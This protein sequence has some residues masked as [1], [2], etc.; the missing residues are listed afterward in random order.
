MFE[1]LWKRKYRLFTSLTLL[2]IEGEDDGMTANSEIKELNRLICKQ[3]N[4]KE[5][6][7]CKNCKVYQLINKIATQ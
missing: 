3:C 2:I 4:E 1:I 5:Y 6:E 7:K